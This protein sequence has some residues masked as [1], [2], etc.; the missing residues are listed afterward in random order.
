MLASP[1]Q[2]GRDRP[3]EWRA[4]VVPGA[5]ESIAS[6]FS[7][8]MLRPQP[9]PPPRPLA[10]PPISHGQTERLY[11]PKARLVPVLACG[12]WRLEIEQLGF[13]GQ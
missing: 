1:D 2:D 8:R 6:S 11:K 13:A 5:K 10:G 4:T 7:G 9:R 12:E 3:G